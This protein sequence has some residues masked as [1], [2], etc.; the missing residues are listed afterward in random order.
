MGKKLLCLIMAICFALGLTACGGESIAMDSSAR[1]DNTL[2]GGFVAETADYVYFINGVENYA[3]TY[4]TGSVTK[5]ALLRTPKSTF[6][7]AS[8]RTYETVVSKLIVADDT[9][10]GFYIYG[11]YVYYAVPSAEN[12]KTGTVKNDQLNFFR[13]KLDGTNTSKNITGR[14]FG[15]SATYRYVAVGEKVFLVVYSTELYVY[16]AVNGKEVYTTE[17]KKDANAEDKIDVAEVIF[18]DDAVYFT[19]LPV[20]KELSDG[21]NIQKD[22]HHDVY[23]VD[24]SASTVSAKVVLSGIGKN[25]IGN[26]DKTGVDLIGVTIDLLRVDGGKL[27]FSYTSLNKLNA[28]AVYMAIEQ[29]KLGTVD[30]RA[31]KDAGE[32]SIV[33]NKNTT[34]IFADTSIFHGEKMYFVDA[35]K[36][37][38]VYDPAKA[39]DGDTTDLGVS[40]VYYSDIVKTATLD[41]VNKEGDV[42]Y[43]YFHNGDNNYFKLNISSVTADTKEFRINKHAVNATWYTPEVIKVGEAYYFVA[44]YSDVE[45]KSYI[46][47]INMTELKTAYDAWDA[48]ESEDKKEDFY[49][50]DESAED[51]DEDAETLKE[52][53]VRHSLLGVISE[54]DLKVEESAE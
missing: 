25:T 6:A 2:K 12:D 53:A 24:L 38:C 7:D 5:G 28:T 36:G 35:E 10:A 33:A 40:I 34:A 1:T 16:D 20:N 54:D 8:K 52:F 11:D 23:K 44:A 26:D 29:D 18:A 48:D 3:T 51:Y 49:A 13:T 41:F 39:T 27:Y 42:D 22:A 31:W 45:F 47:T 43:L 15:H 19:S 4:K 37:L 46:Y 30:A 21:D 50:T 9:D 32:I 17:A 14:D